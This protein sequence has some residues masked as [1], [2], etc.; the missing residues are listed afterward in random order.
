M[1]RVREVGHLYFSAARWNTDGSL[2][3]TW[4]D[5]PCCFQ[6][7]FIDQFWLILAGHLSKTDLTSLL[8]VHAVVS[9]FLERVE[10]IILTHRVCPFSW[11]AQINWKTRRMENTCKSVSEL[12][13]HSSIINNCTTM[14]MKFF[15]TEFT[16]FTIRRKTVFTQDFKSS[17]WSSL[18]S[19]IFSLLSLVCTF[20]MLKKNTCDLFD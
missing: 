17:K 2:K 7:I 19:S 13:L 14:S 11:I 12:N 3:W 5:C 10:W 4:I 9:S 15:P 20:K 6:V 16:W 8:L 1:A 18:G